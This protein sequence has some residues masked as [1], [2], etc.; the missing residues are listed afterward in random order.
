MKILRA[1]PAVIIYVFLLLLFI[2]QNI[3]AQTEINEK[4]LHDATDDIILKGTN[5]DFQEKAKAITQG[6]NALESENIFEGIINL[7][8]KFLKENLGLLIKLAVLCVFSGIISVLS[9]GDSSKVSYI[10]ILALVF[11]IAFDILKNSL[12][13]AETTIDN[14]LI[15]MQSL[16]PSV[17]ML[18]SGDAPALAVSFHPALFACIQTIVYISR[19]WFLPMIMFTSVLSAINSMTVRFHI[20]K[21]LETCNLFI[22]WGLGLLMTVYIALLSIHGF[23]GAL[24]AGTISKTVKYA[25]ASFIPMVGGVLAESAESVLASMS[26]IR[27]AIGISGILATLSLSLT[28]LLNLLAVSVIFRLVASITEPASDQRIIKLIS[29]FASSISLIFSILLAVCVML[30]ISI[31]M[32]LSLTNLPQMMR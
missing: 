30:I 25:I 2:P 8:F 29:G 20:T 19:E 7:F 6:E 15:F 12:I 23:S 31:A 18:S 16:I 28:P 13:L 26:L 11:S 5:F 24:Q 9:E 4:I 27:N 10:S 22:K 1:R 14:L 32:L 3:F 17:L 21:L